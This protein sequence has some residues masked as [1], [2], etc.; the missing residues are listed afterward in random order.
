MDR[1]G[2]KENDWPSVLFDGALAEQYPTKVGLFP[3]LAVSFL[4]GGRGGGG[5]GLTESSLL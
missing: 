5:V 4:M 2:R 1:E 3:E